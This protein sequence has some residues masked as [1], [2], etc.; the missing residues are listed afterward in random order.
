MIDT[1]LSYVAPHY[2]SGCSKIGSLLCEYCHYDIISDGF[3]ACVLCG[4][5]TGVTGIC[6]VCQVEVARGWCVGERRDA[7]QRL[8]GG[9]KFQHMRAA[10]QPLTELL[11]ARLPELPSEVVVA[12]VPT[13]PNHIRRRGYDHA[14]LVARAFARRRGL[15][16]DSSLR[17]QTSTTQ[18]DVGR[19]QREAQA[20][21]AFRCDQVTYPGATYLLVD[22]IVTTGATVRHAARALRQ[23]GAG[24]VWLATLSRQPLD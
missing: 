15:R 17:R 21:R 7:L 3:S 5:P 14:L 24:E 11:D 22:D 1:I 13:I 10:A 20:R 4:G 2:C 9:Y 8:I 18:H 19:V 12:P 23:A 16:L 6:P